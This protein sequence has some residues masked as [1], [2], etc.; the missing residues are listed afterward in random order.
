[1]DLLLIISGFIFLIAGLIGCIAPIIPGPPLSYVAIILLQIK[2]KTSFSLEFLILT[3]LLVIIV[4]IIDYII[5]VLGT[6]RFGGSKYG[7]WGSTIGLLIGFLFGP[8]GIFLGPF[9]GA[10]IGELIY[11]KELEKA[12]KAAIGS[13]IGFLSGI[14]LKLGVVIFISWH[15]VK[16]VF[17][18]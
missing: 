4:T 9:V 5:P 8:P 17:F 18:S 3:A 7:V 6:K 14:I 12:L 11:G 2:D 13:F 1:M 15:F 16:A 10:L